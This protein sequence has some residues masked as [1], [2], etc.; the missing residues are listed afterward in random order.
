[1]STFQGYVT[2][3]ETDEPVSGLIVAVYISDSIANVS[4]GTKKDSK[5]ADP[6][7][8]YRNSVGSTVTDEHGTFQI[9][10]DPSLNDNS[11]GG[12]FLVAVLAPATSK[13]VTR[14]GSPSPAE[15]ALY[16]TELPIHGAK[17]TE[18]L[19]I[20]LL[21]AQ[22]K[23]FN[24]KLPGE[25]Y[26][27]DAEAVALRY[28]E[29]ERDRLRFK[30]TLTAG[31]GPLRVEQFQRR[32]ASTE[33]ARNFAAKLQAAP[34]ATRAQANFI[35][36]GDDPGPALSHAVE[37]G[38]T[39]IAVATAQ[40]P[41]RVEMHLS[42]DDLL[43]AGVSV[44]EAMP[45]VVDLDHTQ[46][47]R[48]LNARRGGTE[49]V[50]V[51]DLLEAR[52]EATAAEARLEPPEEGE[53]SPV[54]EEVA[55]PAT[56][57]PEDFSAAVNERVLGQLRD[58][59]IGAGEIGDASRPLTAE[60]L[61][62]MLPNIRLGS[63]PTDTPA[64]HDFCHL[65]IAF[66]HV[67]VEAFD[68]A[69]RNDI[70][71][72]YESVV[73]LHE[74]YFE[75]EFELPT[76]CAEIDQLESFLD[77]MARFSDWMNEP[78]PVPVRTYFAS[79]DSQRWTR[80]SPETRAQLTELATE[81]AEAWVRFYQEADAVTKYTILTEEI[82]PMQETWMMIF[83][84]AEEA[85]NDEFAN[86]RVVRLLREIKARLSEPYAFHY[87]A[88]DSVNFGL[89]L[90]YRQ[91]WKPGP[92]Q[93]GDLVATVPLAPGEKRKFTTK[94]ILKRTRAETE[95][96]KA[97]SS[98]NRELTGTQRVEAEITQRASLR[99]NFKMTAEGS[100]RFGIGEITSGTEFALDQAQESSRV[101]K[102]FREAV[103][104]AAQEYKQE[105]SLEVKTTDEVTSETTTSGEIA[106]P[107]NELS[108]TY[109][110][111]ELERQ[112]TI[113][114]RIHRA[115]PVVLVA[116]DVPAPNEITESWLS[117]HEWIL[118]RVI[119]DDSL[120]LALDYISDAFAGEEVSVSVRRANWEA[121]VGLVKQLEAT[122]KGLKS[123]RDEMRE[124]LVTT[125]ESRA[126]AA[127]EEETTG[128]KA[129]LAILTGG[130][131]LLSGDSA[132]EQQAEQLEVTRKAIESRLNYLEEALR[133]AQERMISA[134]AA[135]NEATS[136][137][138]E[139]L[140]TQTNRRVA[141][142]QLRMHVKQNILYYMQAIWDHEPPD[143][144][145]F[146]LYH[147]EVDLPE[148]THR[149]AHLRLATDADIEAGLP[150]IDHG[151][152]RWIVEFDPPAPPDPDEPNRKPLVEIAD[153]DRP[154]GYKGNYI[155][156]PLKTCL[157]LTNFMM[158]E[159]FDDYF[160]V[161]DPDMASNL[162]VE[163]LLEYT[164]ALLED[165]AIEPD[166]EQYAALRNIVMSKLQRP[167]RDSD[168][169]VVPTGELY[170]EA[171]LGDHVLME[172]FKLT[173]RFYDMAKVRAE[174]RQVE[175]DNLRR[176]AR[177]IQAE[178]DLGDP[179]VDKRIVV[180]GGAAVHVETP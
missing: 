168:L 63:G 120:R 179:E 72:L 38:V 45:P 75:E 137:Y 89:L 52:R 96:E 59:P 73:R 53:T 77:E 56:E 10:I 98:K 113:S 165:G 11:P 36:R 95:L 172:P 119:L 135:L 33:K 54:S 177:L 17:Q 67:W 88:P 25:R 109:L 64:F 122:V 101:K 174:W 3:K 43:H 136:A 107:N 131:S 125:E 93:V 99:N 112:Y 159:Y 161:R 156:F 1:M 6:F 58:M 48:L 129:W 78:V 20:R 127:A 84:T 114:E 143:Q 142:D 126:R 87:F 18:K 139:A 46:L 140:Q 23:Q 74:D 102:D 39:H 40:A 81:V 121:Q 115:T 92:Y 94:Q 35:K 110:L 42:E 91:L 24:I 68:G 30:A 148:S 118:R 9:D 22:L 158:R 90:T 16:W 105:R 169:I 149:T 173:H 13:A 178:P 153:L 138:S 32:Q 146:R 104:K 31:I 133:E 27:V 62:A 47:C 37:V 65:Q 124:L 85:E 7:A 8:I 175:L 130:L 76:E 60:E 26:K 167:T 61:N 164:E 57:T 14:A 155:I 154:L 29:A 80:L 44:V 160:G 71:D 4:K 41:A 176:A 55:T 86:L 19:V 51:R 21:S 83:G 5:A 157:Y 69:L 171:L 128:Q 132:A 103:L 79:V 134:E 70:E 141:I 111:Y 117:A 66:P 162:S 170:M 15:R 34:R 166:S 2:L 100:F 151:G 108:V 152:R 106:N 49:L 163:E 150:T 144:R 147:V 82:E 50:R 123:A 97:L 116:Q 180:E 145:F 12:T 28:V